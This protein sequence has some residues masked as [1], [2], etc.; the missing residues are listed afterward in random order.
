L[1]A[2]VSAAPLFSDNNANND[3][4][5]RA[6]YVHIQAFSVKPVGKVKSQKLKY[7]DS[8]NIEL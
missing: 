3:K 7:I 6:H 5:R 8:A 2:V 4:T 1:A